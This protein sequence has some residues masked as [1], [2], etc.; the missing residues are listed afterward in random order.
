M[1]YVNA[2]VAGVGLPLPVSGP[3]EASF[4][5]RLWL[6]CERRQGPFREVRQVSTTKSPRRP[7]GDLNEWGGVAKSRPQ[8]DNGTEKNLCT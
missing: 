3:V 1:Q 8:H 7:D 2:T 6:L 5:V 4:H